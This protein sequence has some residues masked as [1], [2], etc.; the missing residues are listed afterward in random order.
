MASES[1]VHIVTGKRTEDHIT[2]VNAGNLNAGVVGTG[3]YI[4]NVGKKAAASIGSGTVTIA[5]GTV[6]HNG[7]QIDIETPVTLTVSP[8]SVGQK[9]NDLV[10]IRYTKDHD[11]IENAQLMILKGT[12]TVA[13]P[14]DP[15][16]NSGSI[17]YGV[18]TSDMVLYRIQL[19]GVTIKPPIAL[20]HVISTLDAAGDRT[21]MA[22]TIYS[23]TLG[24]VAADRNGHVALWSTEDFKRTFGVNP[25]DCYIGLSNRASGESGIWLATPRW[26]GS[27]VYTT[28]LA[29]QSDGSVKAVAGDGSN[30]LPVAYIVIVYPK[31]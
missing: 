3:S 25:K 22:G 1:Q 5:E 31:M 7:R 29:T 21:V 10:V 28:Q 17:L 24:K 30:I 13:T 12:P 23:G 9:R 15:S 8:G 26:N 19:D 18:S 16:Y 11:G 2:S 20:A 27:Y 14:T 6:V 4:L